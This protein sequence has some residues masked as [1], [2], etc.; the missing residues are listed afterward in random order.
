[1]RP[2]YRADES[3]YAEISREMVAS[4]DWI[5]PRLNGFKYF[6]KPP[7]QYWTTA[8]LFDAFGERDWVARLWP[9]LIG[10]AGIVMVLHAGNR[11]FGPPVGIYAAAVLAASPLYVLLGQ[12]NTLDMNVTFFLSAAMFAFTLGHMRLFWALFPHDVLSK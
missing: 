6:E 8:A 12:V 1:M 9:A 4:G 3:R 7:L 10:F 5:T 2:L 11:L